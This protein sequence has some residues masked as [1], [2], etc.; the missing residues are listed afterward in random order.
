MYRGDAEIRKREASPAGVIQPDELRLIIRKL[1][2]VKEA[3][4]GE[5]VIKVQDGRIVYVVQSIGEQ[6]RIDLKA[7]S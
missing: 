1:K 7:D 6:V 5:L 4:Y 3:G 2:P